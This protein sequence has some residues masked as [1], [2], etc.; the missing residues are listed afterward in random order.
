MTS[1]PCGRSRGW[2]SAG[3]PPPGKRFEAADAELGALKVADQRKRP[4]DLLLDF[5]DDLGAF[6]MVVV[7]AVREIQPGGIHAGIDQRTDLLARR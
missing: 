7:G 6:G 4:A 1:P 5:T 2:S 3:E